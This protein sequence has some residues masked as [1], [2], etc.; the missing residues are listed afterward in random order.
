MNRAAMKIFFVVP[1]LVTASFA[2][3][4]NGGTPN[5][6]ILWAACQGVVGTASATEYILF[7]F[8]G[9]N[10]GC[11]VITG[12]E[13]PVPYACTMRNL[14]VKASANGAVAGSGVV[15]VYRNGSA[16]AITCTLGTGSTCSDTTDTGSYAAGDSY[17]V[18]VTTGQA[19][20][21]TANLRVTLQCQ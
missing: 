17:K 5:N 15:K 12:T 14:F 13:M 3:I 11:T 20:D 10:A 19:S 4:N 7:P 8:Q 18:T 21:T 16:G 2:Q 6:G 9:T 1:I